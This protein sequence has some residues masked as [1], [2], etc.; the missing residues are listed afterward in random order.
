MTV[1]TLTGA[2]LEDVWGA[3]DAPPNKKN[4]KKTPKQSSQKLDDIMNSYYPNE[5]MDRTRYS[6]TQFPLSDMDGEDPR[7]Q[8]DKH[9]DIYPQ[10][11]YHEDYTAAENNKERREAIKVKDNDAERER[12]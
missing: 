7:E 4:K 8:V 9:V 2:S 10:I 3:Y 5:W 12:M 11:Q 6:R 1:S